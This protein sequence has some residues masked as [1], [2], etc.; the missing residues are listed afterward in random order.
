MS[1]EKKKEIIKAKILVE[2]GLCSKTTKIHRLIDKMGE[3]NIPVGYWFLTMKD[4][5]GSKKLGEVV[6][7]YTSN[8]QKYYMSGKSICF[9]GNQGT[10]KTMSSICILKGAIKNGFSA[11]Y[12]TAADMLGDLTEKDS[13]KT[14]RLLKS[15]D[16]L[17]IDE[18]DSRF[19]TSDNMR[20]FFSGKYELIFRHRAHNQLPT[21]L[22][23]N[24]TEDISNVFFGPGVQSIR[25]L[26][27]Q[28]L[29]IYPVVG[30]DYRKKINNE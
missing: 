10:G 18:L 16:F 22:C 27:K 6:Q 29:D 28:Y 23:T 14:R 3:A 1:I 13:G 24:E 9:A 21:I 7:D 12:T 11:H 4:F 30:L 17:V 25:S 15:V 5:E 20:E 19:F 8:I 2:N 26:N